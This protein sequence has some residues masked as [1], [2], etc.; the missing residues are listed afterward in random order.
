MKYPDTRTEEV[1]DELAG[2]RTADPY[3]WLEDGAAEEVR[4]WQ[5]QQNEL[6][7]SYVRSWTGFE[8]VR[9]LVRAYATS[10]FW[11]VPRRAGGHWF[12]SLLRDGASQSSVVVSDQPL[13]PGRVLYDPA[14]ESAPAPFLSWFSPSP[15]GTL[16]A[17]G[18]CADGSEQNTIRLLD[19]ATGELRRGP[20]ARLMDNWSG[21]VAW[22][23]DSSGFY[24]TV[25]DGAAVDIAHR[26]TFYDIASSTSTDIA[27]PREDQREYRMIQPS[28]DGKRILAYEGIT[29][30]RPLAV[31]DL[32]NPAAPV[33][34]PFITTPGA[35]VHGHLLGDTYF[36][37]TDL[38]APR[39]RVV[40]ISLD[41]PDPADWSTLLPESDAVLRSLTPVGEQ[42]YLSELVDTYSRIRILDQRGTVVGEVP[43]PGKG[44]VGEHPLPYMNLV[45]RG[46][47]ESLIFAFSSLTASWGTYL[48]LAG[49]AEIA[50]LEPPA[51]RLDAVVEDL[52]A[53]SRDG[54]RIPYHVVRQ[55][56][57]TSGAAL[58]YA[59]GGYNAPWMPH[60]P[61]PMAALVA[62]GGI[63]VHAH[64]R[65]GGEFG[66]TWW[67]GGR[68]QRKQNCY[69]DLYAIAEDLIARGITTPDRLA[70]TGASNGGLM[71]GVAVTQRPDLW[72]AV[73]PRVPLLDLI[74]ACR[75][76]YGYN[77]V[78]SE[79]ADVADADDV[80]RL[81]TF[82]PYHLVTD[83]RF[84]AVFL[85]AG[86]TDPRCPPWHARKLAA[87]LQAA[88][89]G[90]APILLRVW[91]NVG[92]GWAT[93]K[94]IE[95]EQSAEWLAF[96]CRELG[97]L[98]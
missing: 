89:H 19:V 50:E 44:V 64:L 97:L 34:R 6:S 73:V 68:M 60:F 43:L 1:S 81:L 62:A 45:P 47:R 25:L 94:Q 90:A 29:S 16:L 65:G 88:Q 8:Q 84:P 83:G 17:L 18:L 28:A 27:A 14:A 80:R 72:Q 12:R 9:D 42:W 58:L 55:A 31:A 98:A 74:G 7:S 71:A 3:R 33:W 63:F 70:V 56:P 23:P 4:L 40:A 92:H 52:W 53:V 26:L 77:A 15:D 39:G 30:P 51:V 41:K 96:V 46:D 75:E 21:G 57:V 32:D 82:S 24:L 91:D 61:G 2:V 86:A 93:D 22:L 69:D 10:H 11:A 20:Q 49:A 36:A 5:K 85:D 67:E 78:S 38:D 76:T 79:F 54:T 66:R 37:I 35:A 59:Y 13:G 95:V 87:R 48:H